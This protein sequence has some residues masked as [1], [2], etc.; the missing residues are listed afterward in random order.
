MHSSV[1][2]AANRSRFPA[3]AFS[4]KGPAIT[5]CGPLW[6]YDCWDHSCWGMGGMQPIILHSV[7]TSQGYTP[8]QASTSSGPAELVLPRDIRQSCKEILRIKTYRTGTV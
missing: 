5:H 6:G 3:A 4:K 2:N 8:A 1:P 7:S